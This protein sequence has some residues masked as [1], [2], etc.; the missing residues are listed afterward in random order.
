MT[1]WKIPDRDGE[2]FVSVD[3]DGENVSLSYDLQA[4]G[5]YND[6][7]KNTDQEILYHLGHAFDALSYLYGRAV[8]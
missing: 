5:T 3:F 6:R 1:E 8:G 2:M 7:G 4:L